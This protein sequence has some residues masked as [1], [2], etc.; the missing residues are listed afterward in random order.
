M[1]TP[2]IIGRNIREGMTPGG[3]TVPFSG[4]SRGG[5]TTKKRPMGNAEIKKRC[6]EALAKRGLA[7]RITYR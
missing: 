4:H 3:L 6:D 2:I 7:D 1:S 5:D